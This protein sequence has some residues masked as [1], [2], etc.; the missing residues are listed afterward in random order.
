M[1]K[2]VV[3]GIVIGAVAIAAVL[4][5]RME[6]ARRQESLRDVEV[7]RV[8]RRDIGTTVK[9]TGVIKPMVGAQAG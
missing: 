6:N 5:A 8:S 7:V 9:A 2:L 1:K 3:I 4:R